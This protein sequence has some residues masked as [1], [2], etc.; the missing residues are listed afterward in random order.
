MA[1]TRGHSQDF[2]ASSHFSEAFEQ[3]RIR[4]I[5]VLARKDPV[6]RSVRL[7][8]P[9]RLAHL[10][11]LPVI[12]SVMAERDPHWTQIA[13][14][15]FSTLLWPHVAYWLAS[16]FRDSRRAELRN[17]LIDMCLVGA[18]SGLGNMGVWPT[19]AVVIGFNAAMLSAGGL[20]TAIKGLGCFAVFFLAGLWGSGQSLQIPASNATTA[21]SFIGL[22]LFTS[23]LGMHSLRLT[24]AHAAARRALVTQQSLSETQNRKVEEHSRQVEAERAA[25]EEAR[26]AADLA[27]QAKSKFLAVMS[28]E[29][30]TPLNAIIGYAEMLQDDADDQGNDAIIPDLQRIRS[31]GRHLLEL[32]NSVL[33]LSKIEAGRME[34]VLSNVDARK[35]VEDVGST[36]KMLAYKGDNTFT[37][38][39]QNATLGLLRCDRVKLKQVLLNLISNAA[40]FTKHGDITLRVYSQPYGIGVHAQECLFFDVADTGIGMT[41]EQSG[42]LF[43][44]FSQADANISAEYGGTGLG[45]AISRRLCQMMGGDVTVTTVFG[46][47]S[48]F[49]VRLPVLGPKEIKHG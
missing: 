7:N 24:R 16:R 13:L 15:L 34:L 10:V 37:L 5:G 42:R 38:Q 36:A 26:Q 14:L 40:K 39:W 31:S 43:Q 2:A 41:P 3:A 23:A 12:G 25:A 45:L 47:G 46:K 49:T 4:R 22:L 48:V 19:A 27:N 35:L 8:Y 11:L 30:R 17:L 9:I 18:L 28:H 32:I 20:S 29:L 6:H 33:D 44:A 21:L 1:A